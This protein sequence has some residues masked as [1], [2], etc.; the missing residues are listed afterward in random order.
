MSILLYHSN[1]QV[2]FNKNVTPS[3]TARPSYATDPFLTSLSSH[4][5]NEQNFIYPLN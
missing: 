5:F 3:I 2:F 4:Y 1:F